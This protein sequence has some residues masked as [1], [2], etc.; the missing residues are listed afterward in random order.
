MLHLSSMLYPRTKRRDDPVRAPAPAISTDARWLIDLRWGAVAGQ[1]VTITA[2]HA[3]LGIALPLAPLTLIVL[4]YGA[5]NALAAVW[6]ERAGGL[7]RW[8]VGALF[9]ADMLE[10]TALLYFTSGP[11]NPFG[12]LYLV[13]LSLAAIVL[14]ATWAWGLCAASIACYGVLFLEHRD[15]AM[16]FEP[17]HDTSL[18]LQGTWVGFAVAAVFIVAFVSRVTRTL[19]ARNAEL[20]AERERAARTR[21]LALLASLTAGAAHELSTPLAT[22]AVAAREIERR[23]ENDP[24]SNGGTGGIG[25]ARLIREQVERCRD[26]LAGIAAHAGQ[27]LGEPAET[28][29]VPRL[30]EDAV[31]ETGVPMRIRA[32][33]TPEARRAVLL[34]WPRA[35]RQALGNVLRNALEAAPGGR[36]VSL[37]ASVAGAMLRLAIEDQGQGMPEEVLHRAGEPFFSTKPEG[38]GMGLGLF[39]ARSVAE[40]AGGALRL[41]SRLGMGTTVLIELPLATAP[42]PNERPAPAIRK[43]AGHAE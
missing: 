33:L 22:I 43:P 38:Q 16:P 11:F 41:S 7:P 1:A 2:V 36:P 18:H 19:A 37:R 12:V 30:I 26:S 14:P 10:L 5:S 21:Q 24:S 25:D 39:L 28:L 15:L 27:T 13:N 3:G 34:T 40:Q 4:F 32:E 8:A 42:G 17:H 6:A 9:L 31:A 35:L 29:P 23:L 20:S